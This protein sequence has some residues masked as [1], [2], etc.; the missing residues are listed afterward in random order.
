MLMLS[1]NISF[2]MP[3]Y[4]ADIVLLNPTRSGF[5]LMTMPAAMAVF[6]RFGGGLS[7][8]LGSRLIAMIGFSIITAVT[9]TFSRLPDNSPLW[10]LITLLIIFGTGAGLMLAAL[11]RAALN[12][13]P[14][15][16]LGTSSGIYSMIRFLGSASGAAFGGILLQFYL[17]QDSVNL[18]A[19]Y[20]HVFQW[21]AGFALLGVMTATFL[22]KTESAFK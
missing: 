16:D 8:R 19:A 9:F 17:D 15:A 7:D 3:L 1:G 2:I 13:M 12:D 4:L 11:H 6:V 10:L 14:E 18:L 22:P 5:F 21:F 20:Q